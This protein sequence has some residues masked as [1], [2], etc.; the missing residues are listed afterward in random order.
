MLVPT[1][2][3]AREVPDRRHGDQAIAS[4]HSRRV[5]MQGEAAQG[6]LEPF[7]LRLNRNGALDSCFDAF[8]SREPAPTSLENALDGALAPVR[9]NDVHGVAIA[10]RSS[11]G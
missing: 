5:V 4:W 2:N 3:G 11:G 10:R 6:R 9:Q 1:A 7:P 8:S